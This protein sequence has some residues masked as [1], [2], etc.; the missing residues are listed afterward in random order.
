MAITAKHVITPII[1]SG[2]RIMACCRRCR[3]IEIPKVIQ[4]P[5]GA[6]RKGKLL[7]APIKST[8]GKFML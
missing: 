8:I 2:D 3:D 1:K 6:I 5:D 7:N 4:I